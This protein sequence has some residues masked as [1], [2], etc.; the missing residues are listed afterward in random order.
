MN[1]AKLDARNNQFTF[2]INQHFAK[3]RLIAI[4]KDTLGRNNTERNKAK[5]LRKLI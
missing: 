4:Y 3:K 5:A 2:L 1:K